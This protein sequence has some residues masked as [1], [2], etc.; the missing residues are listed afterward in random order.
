MNQ[1]SSAWPFSSPFLPGM[2]ILINLRSRLPP[3]ERALELI[4]VFYRG[5]GWYCRPIQRDQVMDEILPTFYPDKTSYP[6]SVIPSEF[7]EM[8]RDNPHFL[9]LLF[10]ILSVGAISGSSISGDDAE[11]YFQNARASMALKSVFEHPG[12]ACV[13]ATALMSVY[14]VSTSRAKTVDT[15]W[16]M[17]KFATNLAIN[18]SL[19]KKKLSILSKLNDIL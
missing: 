1:A 16:L 19:Q 3:W 17:M 12:L 13:Q 14:L 10:S 5:I 4:D 15:P 6:P 11:E 8:G 18:V 7:C 9:A 2:D